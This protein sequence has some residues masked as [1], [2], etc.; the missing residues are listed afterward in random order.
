MSVENTEKSLKAGAG[1]ANPACKPEPRGKNKESFSCSQRHTFLEANIKGIQTPSLS[2]VV[3]S[4][5]PGTTQ[6]VN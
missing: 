4:R 1:P 5:G 2:P 3:P 6:E